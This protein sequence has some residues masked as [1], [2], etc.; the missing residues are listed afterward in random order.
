MGTESLR[1]AWAL[2]KV[3]DLSWHTNSSE[4]PRLESKSTS[5]AIPNPVCARRPETRLLIRQAQ[6]EQEANPQ[7]AV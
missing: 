4:V 2:L 6:T 7:G 5:L 1:E 3:R